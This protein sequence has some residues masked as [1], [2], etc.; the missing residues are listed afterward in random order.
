[1]EQDPI[2]GMER[3]GSGTAM[4]IKELLLEV[5]EDVKEL[6][7]SSLEMERHLGVQAQE[8]TEIK[9]DLRSTTE[10]VKV[11]EDVVEM[12]EGQVS[13]VKGIFGPTLLPAFISTI[14]LLILLGLASHFLTGVI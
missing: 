1:M 2:L 7:K 4:T 6:I 14:N 13:F 11:I 12:R 3:N 5:R 9:E 8:I 10:R